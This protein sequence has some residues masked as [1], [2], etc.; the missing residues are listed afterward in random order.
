MSRDGSSQIAVRIPIELRQRIEA[1][2]EA[3]R[4][5][6]SN[7]VVLMLEAEVERWERRR[8]VTHKK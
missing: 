8:L 7:V 5:S 6:F 1:L 2:A 4:R 3:D